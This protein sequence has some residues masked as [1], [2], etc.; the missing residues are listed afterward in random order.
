M[1]LPESTH[2]LFE[3]THHATVVTVNPDGSPQASLVWVQRDGDEILI[4][5][6]GTRPKARNL[7]R[8]PRVTLLIEDHENDEVR[9]L[10]QYLLLHGTAV[11]TGPDIPG[12]FDALMDAQARRYLGLPRYP[13]ENRSSTTAVIVRIT[14]TRITGNGPWAS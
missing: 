2:R 5:M 4:G 11:V 10:R 7:R 14:P 3:S 8:D 1:K 6:E 9:G 12:E 13:F